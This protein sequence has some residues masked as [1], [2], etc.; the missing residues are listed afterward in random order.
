M[1]KARL[2]RRL[3]SIC[4]TA[5]ASVRHREVALYNL[6]VFSDTRGKS[7]ATSANGPG[8]TRWTRQPHRRLT[9]MLQSRLSQTPCNLTWNPHVGTHIPNSCDQSNNTASTDPVSPYGT[10]FGKLPKEIRILVWTDVLTCNY[11]IINAHKF[12]SPQEPLMVASCRSN[13]GIDTDLLRTC[14]AIYEETFPI[15][16]STNWFVFCAPSEITAFAFGKLHFPLGRHFS[17]HLSGHSLK[18]NVHHVVNSKTR[19]AG[20]LLQF[21]TVVIT[22]DKTVLISASAQGRLSLL[23]ST[24]LVLRNS[25]PL[26][27]T[28]QRH[29]TPVLEATWSAWAEFFQPLSGQQ[30]PT[31][32]V[33]KR[34]C[35]VFRHWEL[36]DSDESKLRVCALFYGPK[37]S[38][39][40]SDVS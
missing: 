30:S 31:F 12:T 15:L 5:S 7:P 32:P 23:R 18:Q 26:P 14:S 1:R 37:S 22:F 11:P 35:L 25:T 29:P 17:S 38:K 13:E 8:W 19:V 9:L 20:H 40:Q 16:Y 3:Y 21:L 10:W 27:P 33:L 2:S 34:L 28:Q 6:S 36:D 24:T 4:N 39:F